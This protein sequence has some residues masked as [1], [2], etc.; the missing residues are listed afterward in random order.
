MTVTVTIRDETVTGK[1][2][3]ELPL[4]FQD[5]RITVREL[6]RERVYQEVQDFNLRQNDQVFRGLVQPADAEPVIS[7]DRTEYHLTH[8]RTIDWKPQFENAVKAFSRNGFLILI[9]DRQAV[10]LEEEFNIHSS[11]EIRFV[12]LTLL[13]GG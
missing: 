11:T 8:K 10:A 7:G 4:E 12:K 6:L 5:E 2:F 1:V 3:H 13:V 9:N